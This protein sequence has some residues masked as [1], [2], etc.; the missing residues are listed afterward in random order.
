M[1]RPPMILDVRIDRMGQVMRK[2][3]LSHM[4]TTKVQISLRIRWIESYVLKILEIF[5]R[6]AAQIET[7]C[8]V[9][10]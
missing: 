1:R 4:Q 3:V 6:D 9:K 8:K 2:R 5:S 10:I 7:K